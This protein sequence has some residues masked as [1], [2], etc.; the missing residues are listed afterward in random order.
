LFNTIHII[1]KYLYLYKD[2]LNDM[3]I[4][5]SKKKIKTYIFVKL[6]KQDET[7]DKII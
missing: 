3:G 4:Y 5:L 6:F 2:V 7:K 1:T